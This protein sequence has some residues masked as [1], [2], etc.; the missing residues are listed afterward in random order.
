MSDS[1]L[2]DMW[3]KVRSFYNQKF[4]LNY[5]QRKVRTAIG[6]FLQRYVDERSRK[7]DVSI[8]LFDFDILLDSVARAFGNEF[9]PIFYGLLKEKH[10]RV[11]T[12]LKYYTSFNYA[13][14]RHFLQRDRHQASNF[15]LASFVFDS[16]IQLHYISLTF[17]VFVTILIPFLFYGVDFDDQAIPAIEE[18]VKNATNNFFGEMKFE[19]IFERLRYR[20]LELIHLSDAVKFV[21][22]LRCIIEERDK[23]T[24][25]NLYKNEEFKAHS[26]AIYLEETLQYESM[27]A[28]LYIILGK[29]ETAI[30]TSDLGKTKGFRARHKSTNSHEM[31]QTWKMIKEDKEKIRLDEISKQLNRHD[32]NATTLVYYIDFHGILHCCVLNGEV[33][34]FSF[35]QLDQKYLISQMQMLLK[36][37]NVRV[38]RGFSFFTEKN[39]ESNPFNDTRACSQ[40]TDRKP[41]INTNTPIHQIPLQKATSK[42][43]KLNAIWASKNLFRLILQPVKHLFKGD[44]LIIVPD[45][46]LFFLPFSSLLDENGNTLSMN[47]SVQIVPAVH[48]LLSSL[49]HSRDSDAIGPALFLGNPKLDFISSLP[50]ATKEVQ[51]LAALF[52]T[53][54]IIHEHATKSIVYRKLE[55]VSI[56]HVAS[57]GD[58]NFGW[59]YFAPDYQLVEPGE[60]EELAYML[61]D[62]ELKIFHV[63][64]R[65]VFLSCCCTGRGSVSKNGIFGIARAFLDSGARSVI[66]T[67][68]PIDDLT[69]LEFTH[70]FYT[71]LC[72]EKSVCESLRLTMIH[73]Q[74]H[75]N[76]DFRSY[77]SWAPFHVLGE[78][79]KFT[80]EEIEKIRELSTLSQCKNDTPA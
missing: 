35:T 75:D 12:A 14:R 39:E 20:S 38:P 56:F 28:S 9:H 62:T 23:F 67:L 42:L 5:I 48:Y 70:K 80:K 66:V 18:I 25:L 13:E 34:L 57:H 4:D 55:E 10:Q 30:V 21:N 2:I 69:T 47:Y 59:I 64:A 60:S 46:S 43:K 50:Y 11:F 53:T 72:E 29:R 73:F 58:P 32:E 1:L 36:P 61:H 8:L 6:I 78:D 68:W 26:R 19:H 41:F 71:F 74:N 40:V 22:I 51:Q 17:Q 79:I 44:K 76:P 16:P 27:L 49:T 3:A 65:L 77:R 37:C 7:T 24:F 52:N 63:K 15:F 45:Q 54:P 33:T 31:N